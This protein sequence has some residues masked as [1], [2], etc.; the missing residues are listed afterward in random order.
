MKQLFIVNSAKALKTGVADDLTVL[1]AGQL[2]FFNLTPEASGA[3][4][5]K[6]LFITT[7]PK[8]NF[9]IAIGKPNNSQAFVIPEV[10]VNTLQVVEAAHAAGVNFTA[11]I[12]IPTPVAGKTYTLVLVKLGVGINGERN[13]WSESIY[14]PVNS[15]MTANQLAAKFRDA[16]Q[17]KADAGSINITVSGTNAAVTLTGSNFEDWKLTAG[18]DLFGTTVNNTYAVPAVGD[19]AYVEKLARECAADKGFI[20][21]D[22]ESQH[23]YPGY[24]EAVEDTTYNVFTLRFA[25]G[26]A[27]AA[28]TDSRVYQIVHIAV[29]SSNSSLDTI[30]AVLGQPVLVNQPAAA[31]GNS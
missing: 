28:Q 19:K 23:L 30:K 6:K 14:V 18:D 8:A 11:T 29:P 20:N 7:A 31:G 9:G 16:F 12:T 22:L 4:A 15:S 27:A 26:R 17:A 25:V 2:G 13:K 10:D 24:P 3:N 5:G 1:D 21:L